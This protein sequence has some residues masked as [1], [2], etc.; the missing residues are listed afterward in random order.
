MEAHHVPLG[1]AEQTAFEQD[2][3]GDTDFTDVVQVS[4][5][6]QRELI[7]FGQSDGLGQRNA[8]GGQAF[9]M[10]S[11]IAVALFHRLSQGE[12]NGFGFLERIGERLVAQH[13]ADAG[14]DQLGLER[15][16]QEIVGAGLEAGDFGVHAL[17][18]GD[19][20]DRRQPGYGGRI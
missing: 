4:A 2:G 19:H 20:E 16:D 12:K 18:A 8:V 9:A 7:V 1:V 3:I 5:A 13:G 14:A 10:P 6:K 11:G 17:Y 15:L